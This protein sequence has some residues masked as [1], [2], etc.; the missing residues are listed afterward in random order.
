M[1][2]RT[3]IL[4]A[5]FLLLPLL[6]ATAVSAKL[7]NL[8]DNDPQNIEE[9]DYVPDVTDRVARLSFISGDVRVRRGDSQ[10]WERAVLNL[11]LV[12]GDE[13]ATDPNGRCEI[14]FNTATHVRLAEN[15]VLK[16]TAVKDE[17]I[18]V[19]LPQGSLSLVAN[20]FDKARSYF[21]ID[22]PQTTIAVERSG[23]FRVDAGQRSGDDVRVAVTKDG[24][25]RVYSANSGFTL[26]SGRSATL[27]ISGN[28]AGEWQTAEAERF[29]DD[30]DSWTLD[31]DAVIAKLL[32]DAYYDKYYDRDM[33][34]AEDLGSNG[35]WIYTRQYGYV[36]RPYSSAISGYS[37]WSP[38]RYGQ[39]RWVAPYGWTWVGDEPW[40]WATYHYGRWVWDNG[41]WAWTPYGYYRNSRSWW[42][43]A[44]VVLTVLNNNVCWYPLPYNYHHYNYNSHHGGSH[45]N[46]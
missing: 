4:W 16:L 15:S 30:F 11:P 7:L 17:G 39:W 38:Y 13:I 40:G 41:Y 2:S 37:D 6:S 35:Q 24:E 9:D 21:E 42:Q 29:A 22:A 32:N 14:Q 8:P 19:S 12:E 25:A 43:P 45:H 31:R 28:Y 27:A 33:Y 18:A 5:V 1:H 36:W 46:N 26:R 23:V 3:K 44:L 20:N 10:E 34:G